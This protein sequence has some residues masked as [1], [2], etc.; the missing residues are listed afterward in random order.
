ML[1]THIP[2]KIQKCDKKRPPQ[3][4]KPH[5]NPTIHSTYS[6]PSNFACGEYVSE[7]VFYEKVYS[8]MVLVCLKE[9]HLMERWNYEYLDLTL[10]TTQLHPSLLIYVIVSIL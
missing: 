3:A 8:I 2:R 9:E 6:N 4:P 1:S 10:S 7:D 5:V